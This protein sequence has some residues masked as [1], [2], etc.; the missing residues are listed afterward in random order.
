MNKIKNSIKAILL[1]GVFIFSSCETTDLDL[2][3]NPNALNPVQADPDLLL[4]RVQIDFAYLV[5]SFGNVGADLTRIGYMSGKDYANAYS[6][7][8]FDSRWRSAYSGIMQDIS[9]MNTKALEK[10]LV[11]HIAMGKVMQAYVMLT[12]VDYFGDVPY[13]EALQGADNLNPIA[14][15]G[16]SVYES[17]L[18]LLDEAIA[19]FDSSK[20][21]PQH[22]FYYGGDWDKWIKAANTLKM[23]AYITTRLVDNTAI[24]KFD[25]I[26]TSGNYISSTADDFQF[27]FGTNDTQPDSRHPKYADSYT[28]TGG[29]EYMS[30]SL[31]DYMKGKTD[32]A[33]TNPIN[34][35]I[36]ILFYFYRQSFAT[37]GIAGEPANEVTLECGLVPA[38]L[39]YAGYT[40][41]GVPKGWW[42]RDHGNDN[43]IPPDGFLRTLAGVYPAG[44]KL[45]DL[46]YTDQVNG[47]GNGGN[48]IVPILLAS[49][50]KFMI[51][52][53]QA[54]NGDFATAKTT[55]FEAIDL[56]INKVV[57]FAPHTDRFDWIFGTLSGG[58][59][60]A[61]I[62]DYINWF[63]AD[64]SSDWDAG[65]DT[66]KWNI[67]SQQ[68]FVSLYGN[69]TDAYNY[70]R[71]TG[72]PTT[73][74]PNLEPSPGS[75]PRSMWYPSNYTNTNANATQKSGV[76]V[77][78]FWDTNPAAGFPL[79]N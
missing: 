28:S 56:S 11:N 71:R 40:Y 15:P 34:F 41:C 29:N 10:D 58:P 69:G 66:D 36:R 54:V 76:N 39:H 60:I 45:D 48:G 57:N 61:H 21:S 64:L 44:G 26:V 38:P 55:M 37:P 4:N 62:D 43:G 52:E 27:Q 32:Q 78:I 9:L 46:T 74:Q 77:Q 35:D 5:N 42:G 79:A 68:Y 67:L 20:E 50:S 16:Q 70:Y 33:Y 63:K 12:L 72:Y 47:G 7:D 65:N 25:A 22:D 75:F 18:M 30:N 24:S 31:M 1:L 19:G 2:T 53:L 13:S 14:D 3:Q 23:K 17:A 51:A 73:L 49:S 6:P 59:A 8:S